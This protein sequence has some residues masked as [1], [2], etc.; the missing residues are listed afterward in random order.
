MQNLIEREQPC[1]ERVNDP[2]RIHF[3]EPLIVI[4]KHKL[5]IV[6]T[7]G[8]VIILATVAAF[9]IPNTYTATSKLMPPQQSQSAATAMLG[10]LGPLAG[11]ATKD[12]GLKNPSELYVTM[13]TSR[14]VADTLI[15]RFDLKAAYRVR[16]MTDARQRLA[17]ASEIATGRDG[18]ITIS[19]DDRDPKRAADL[20]NAYVDELTS[21]TRTLA[22]TEAGQRRLFFEQRLQQESADLANAEQDLQR[23]Q[24]KTGILQL[25]SQAKAVI[26]SAAT[27]RAQIA[28]KEV[29]L[30]AMEAFATA[31]NPDRVLAEQELAAL[32]AQLAAMQRSKGTD[33]LGVKMG[34]VPSGGLEYVRKMRELKY[35]E[36]VFELLAKQYEAAKVDEGRNPVVIQVLDKAV[37]PE[38]KSRPKRA[39]LI[40]VALLI[41]CFL[42]ILWAFL[43]EAREQMLSDAALN[44]RF[45]LLKSYLSVARSGERA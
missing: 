30:T 35:H 16:N 31:Q 37:K 6:R 29:Q 43:L 34:N 3:L 5:L 8:I 12:L 21:L 22:M 23:T 24:E 38:T 18:V 28:A 19:V 11:M 13:L 25:D 4:A 36:S 40:M 1:S 2:E 41:G 32:K 44:S 9:L 17:E 20:A 14:T 15:D 39:S 42:S 7:V 45:Q 10:Q 26:E 27:L 33:E